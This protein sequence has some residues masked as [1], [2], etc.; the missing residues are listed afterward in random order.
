MGA[1]GGTSL[2]HAVV[3]GGTSTGIAIVVILLVV[4]GLAIVGGRMVLKQRR[5]RREAEEGGGAKSVSGSAKSGERTW[6]GRKKFPDR[7]PDGSE[8][9]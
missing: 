7:E 2:P 4:V 1:S 5:A 8:M 3:K 6:Y 9:L